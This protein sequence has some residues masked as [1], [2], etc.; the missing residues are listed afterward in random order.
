MKWIRWTILA[1]HIQA[2]DN[3]HSSISPL[4]S[5]LIA[6]AKNWSTLVISRKHV[7]LPREKNCQNLFLL[8]K[9]N[10]CMRMPNRALQQ[11]P[12]LFL[13]SNES[14]SRIHETQH[15]SRIHFTIDPWAR[16]WPWSVHHWAPQEGIEISSDGGG[17]QHVTWEVV[18]GSSPI[19]CMTSP[20]VRLSAA[21]NFAVRAGSAVS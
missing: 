13:V 20:V 11:R 1:L 21:I 15:W 19:G 7:P 12:A 16:N 17:Q 10:V 2:Y 14:N 6:D 8:G 18:K 9:M 3:M 5:L 4:E